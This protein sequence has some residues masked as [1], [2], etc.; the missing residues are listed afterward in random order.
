[1]YVGTHSRAPAEVAVAMR[2]LLHTAED[3]AEL[4]T[5]LARPWPP[6][7]AGPLQNLP[8]PDAAVPSAETV[9]EMVRKGRLALYIL[10]YKGG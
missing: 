3:V 8:G 2:L 7:F 6:A 9:R 1:M 5:A 4:R 10:S